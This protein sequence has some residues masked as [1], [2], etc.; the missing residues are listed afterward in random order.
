VQQP[1]GSRVGIGLRA[2]CL[3][4]AD[5]TAD[6]LAMLES[7]RFLVAERLEA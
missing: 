1:G 6:R 4:R 3:A 2:L 7:R 5:S